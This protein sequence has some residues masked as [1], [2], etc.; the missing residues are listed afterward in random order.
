MCVLCKFGLCGFITT[1]KVYVRLQLPP[2]SYYLLCRL[3]LQ[4]FLLGL[5]Q[6][7]GSFIM[8]DDG[9]KDIRYVS[10]ASVKFQINI[11]HKL[12]HYFRVV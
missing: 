8:H 10:C 4:R 5:H 1:E 9:E 2:Y 11:M 7:D 6:S 3:N 12:M